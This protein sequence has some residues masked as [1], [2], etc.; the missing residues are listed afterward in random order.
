MWI[1]W[2]GSVTSGLRKL[3]KS[4][5]DIIPVFIP[6]KLDVIK[7]PR[8]QHGKRETKNFSL[9]RPP[10]DPDFEPLCLPASSLTI[11]ELWT[12]LIS[13]KFCSG[14]LSSRT[15]KTLLVLLLRMHKLEFLLYVNTFSQLG[16]DK[17]C[18]LWEMNS[19]IIECEPLK[20]QIFSI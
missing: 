7:Y 3:T 8:R 20:L 16:N 17:V 14:E 4:T 5:A 9:F 18:C 11:I 2:S 6:N 1:C 12:N 13:G 10:L 15:L 19:A